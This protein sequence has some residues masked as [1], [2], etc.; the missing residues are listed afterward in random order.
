MTDTKVAFKDVKSMEA[1]TRLVSQFN[2]NI[3]LRPEGE[4]EETKLN[5][6]SILSVMSLVAHRRLELVAQTEDTSELMKTLKP[7][8]A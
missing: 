5:A 4:S 1:F 2:F 7:Y 6:K 3:Y 8:I